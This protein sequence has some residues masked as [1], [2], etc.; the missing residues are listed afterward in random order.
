MLALLA[1]IF[2]SGF[3][4]ATKEATDDNQTEKI[5]RLEAQSAKDREVR[6]ELARWGERL[7]NVRED[8]AEVKKSQAD[9]QALLRRLMQQQF[10][11]R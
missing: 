2:W 10:N 8:V 9:T 6:A 1:N 5:T 7:D 11:P 3:W 4:V